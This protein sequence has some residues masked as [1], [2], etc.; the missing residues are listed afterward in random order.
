MKQDQRQERKGSRTQGE[1]LVKLPETNVIKHQAYQTV[2]CGQN[3]QFLGSLEILGS[4]PKHKSK[5][6]IL[7]GLEFT[8]RSLKVE[9]TGFSEGLDVEG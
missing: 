9:S 5:D 1:K 6:N 2:L 8:E 7:V 3:A 4:K